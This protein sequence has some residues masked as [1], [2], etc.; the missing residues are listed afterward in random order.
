MTEAALNTTRNLS[1]MTKQADFA[2]AYANLTGAAQ[3]I[4]IRSAERRHRAR[5]FEATR[6]ANG[7][8][9]VGELNEIIHD[10]Q[11]EENVTATD[12][13]PFTLVGGRYVVSAT[14]TWG[15]GTV[16][17]QNA[18]GETFASF[19]QNDSA[20]INV[21]YGSYLLAI[22]TASGV[23]VTI[24]KGHYSDGSASI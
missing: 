10:P 5:I 12:A 2:A 9:A 19:T 17:L 14:A 13:T 8:S 7:V 16:T 18:A 15:G 11:P 22:V 1:E 4:A 6:A 24:A 23:T 21:R 20:T 3:G